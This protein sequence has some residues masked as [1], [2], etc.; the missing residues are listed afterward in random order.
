[1]KEDRGSDMRRRLL[2]GASVA[3]MVLV[4]RGVVMAD[5]TLSSMVNPE[6][7]AGATMPALTG[8]IGAAFGNGISK[9]KVKSDNK[10][11]FQVKISGLGLPDSNGIPGNGDE[12]VCIADFHVTM[13]ALNSN[14]NGSLIT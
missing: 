7:L 1:A 13:G 5:G 4:A 12:V 11:H 10:C 8:P 14:L 9:G 3:G 6:S 2:L